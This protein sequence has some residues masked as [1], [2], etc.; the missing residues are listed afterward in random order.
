M[1]T[2]ALRFSIKKQK[3]P[4]R[5]SAE[6]VTTPRPKALMIFAHGAGVDMHHPFMKGIS[7]AL[8][9]L[10]VATLRFQFPYTEQGRK[11]PDRE[12]LLLLAIQAAV[13]KGADLCPGVPLIGAGKSMG[14]RMLSLA[15]AEGM[16]PRIRGLAFFGFPLHAAGKPGHDRAGHLTEIE[17]PMLFLQGTHD[18]L[19]DINEMELVCRTLG[20]HAEL[21]RVEGGD[22]SFKTPKKM[23]R[24]ENVVWR[25]V[26][27]EV[28]RWTDE[29]LAP[30]R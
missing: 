20:S 24:P 8:I 9:G 23:A 19:G 17:L 4:V 1:E 2:K 26:A 3:K 5:L 18:R 12:P 27:E 14:G 30:A 10:E 28:L 7:Q 16:L 6:L 25:E 21:Y 11:S 29:I 22:H 13:D 15:C